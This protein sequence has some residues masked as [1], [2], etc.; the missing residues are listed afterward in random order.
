[1]VVGMPVRSRPE[2]KTR[3]TVRTRRRLPPETAAMIFSELRRRCV[4][5]P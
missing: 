2:C 3:P 1:M 4:A 5:L